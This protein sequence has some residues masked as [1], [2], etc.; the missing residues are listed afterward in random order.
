MNKKQL[1]EMLAEF[2]EDSE[3]VIAHPAG[4][5]WHSTL[6]KTPQSAEIGLIEYSNYF[7][8]NITTDNND[9]LTDEDKRKIV[10]I[11]R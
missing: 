8:E 9:P 1:I 5:Y 11:L 3:I 4:D 7:D 10:V 2:P 6:A